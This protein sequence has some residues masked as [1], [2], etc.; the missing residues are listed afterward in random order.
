[1][2]LVRT[3]L[4]AAGAFGGLIVIGAGYAVR[5]L[6]DA[7]AAYPWKAAA[8]FVV[9]IA[10]ALRGV[11]QHPFAALG[12]ANRVTIVRAML[13][14][15]LVAL[16]GEP[17][18]PRAAATAVVVATVAAILDGVDGWLA[19]RSGMASSFGARFDMEAD[20]LLVLVLSILVW[21]YDKAGAWVLA[22]GLMRYAFV[23]AGWVLP[24]M[25]GTLKPTMRGKAVAVAQTV[26]LIVALA[27]VIARPLS[28]P[29]AAAALAALTWSFGVDV[30]R[31]WRQREE[32]A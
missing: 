1:M 10:I 7:G 21:H 14:S 6:F 5:P 17:R 31:L 4:L 30:R 26:C 18:M 16:A 3:R 23:A 20:A 22:G 24:W 8:F 29:V 19:R 28:V 2:M 12:A 32:G 27:P 9:V 13:V 25:G 15:L 11:H